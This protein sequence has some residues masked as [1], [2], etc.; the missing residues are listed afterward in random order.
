MFRL[1]AEESCM[2]KTKEIEVIVST[3]SKNSKLKINDLQK[4]N[5]QV[6]EIY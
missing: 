2:A 5:N 3:F 1:S 4:Q 6:W